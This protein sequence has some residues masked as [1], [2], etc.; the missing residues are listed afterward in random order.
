MEKFGNAHETLRLSLQLSA[1]SGQL[2]REE[3]SHELMAESSLLLAI[4][5]RRLDRA[6]GLPEK[7]FRGPRH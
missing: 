6:D 5:S 4:L 2:S 1:F 3:R 7:N